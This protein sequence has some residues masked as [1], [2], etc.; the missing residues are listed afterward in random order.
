[1]TPVVATLE[2][3]LPE[4]VP[5]SDDAT[6][7]ILAD[8]PRIVAHHG[9]GDVGEELRAAG[10]VEQCAE[11]QECHDHCRCDT[12]HRAEDT[13]DVEGQVKQQVAV[14][15]LAALQVAWNQMAERDHRR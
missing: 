3:A 5:N 7:A 13:I 4:M 6:I 15:D 12:E 9:D 1:M 8:P 2:T 10:A 14:V 11:K